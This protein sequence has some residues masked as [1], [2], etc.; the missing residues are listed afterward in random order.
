VRCTCVEKCFLSCGANAGCHLLLPFGLVFDLLWPVTCPDYRNDFFKPFRAK[1]VREIR[2][3]RLRFSWHPVS[4]LFAFNDRAIWPVNC[5]SFV[6]GVTVAALRQI[7]NLRGGGGCGSG[8]DSGG[9]GQ[10]SQPS[11]FFSSR[12][13]TA[14]SRSRLAA[15]VG[16]NVWLC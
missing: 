3:L 2:A 13:N 4:I 1:F 15:R 5:E 7:D 8:F 6:V 16:C 11:N 10:L 12:A 9:G 14:S